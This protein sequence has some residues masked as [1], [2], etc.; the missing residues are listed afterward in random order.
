MRV[1]QDTLSRL[2]S[3]IDD[4]TAEETG[5]DVVLGVTELRKSYPE[6]VAVER[7][8]FEVRRREVLGLLGP[9]GAGK[10]TTINMIL[11]VLSPTSG[12]IRIAGIDL[13]RHR[14]RAPGAGQ[15]HEPDAF[16]ARGAE[17][18]DGHCR[19]RDAARPS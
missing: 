4:E 6:V 10:T 12:R 2:H 18:H 13:A 9:N 19:S 5:S 3:C 11:G 17:L 7:V 15:A 1:P 16:N 14:A 8:S